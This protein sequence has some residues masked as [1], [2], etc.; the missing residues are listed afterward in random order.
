MKRVVDVDVRRRNEASPKYF[1]SVM[2]LE[3]GHYVTR[4]VHFGASPFA[5][6]FAWC[7][8]CEKSR[9]HLAWR[10]KR[11]DRIRRYKNEMQ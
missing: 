10:M 8:K 6:D 5:R 4:T 7:S 9:A 3:C 11:R 2:E 1:V